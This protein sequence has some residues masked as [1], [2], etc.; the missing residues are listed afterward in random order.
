MGVAAPRAPVSGWAGVHDP[1]K[2]LVII[3]HS[4]LGNCYLENNFH[5][6]IMLINSFA[7]NFQNQYIIEFRPQVSDCSFNLELK[8]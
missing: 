8:I 1:L 4:L 2:S 3:G 7:W 5:K 6:K